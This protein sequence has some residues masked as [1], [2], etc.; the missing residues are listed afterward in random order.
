MGGKNKQRTKGNVRPSSS[1]RAAEL[2]AREN[3]VVPGFVGFGISTSKEPGYVPAVHGAE[4]IDNLVDADFRLVLRKLSKRDT[5]TKLKAVQEF[6]AMC[7]ERDSDTVAGVLPYWPRIYCKISVDHDRRLREATQQ[8]FEQLILKVKRNLAPYLKGI[9]GHWLIAQCDTYS[10]AASAAN[11][12]FQAAFPL[13]KQPEALSFCKD[14][15]LTVLQDNLL[16]ET[17]DTLSD[18]QSVPEEERQA[19]YVR[20][21]TSSLLALKKLL[22]SLSES[23]REALSQQLAH[24]I[25]QGKFWKY[26][27]HNTPQ[28]RGAFFKAVA[29]LCELV[30]QLV[31]NEAARACSTVLLSIDDSDPVVLPPL[32]EAV[33]HVISSIQDC[34]SHVNARKGVLPKLWTLL[35]EGGRGLA[36]SLHPNML[37]LISKLPAEV[38]EPKLD[39]CSTFLS[40]VTQGKTKRSKI[41]KKTKWWKL[42]KEECCEEFRQRLRQALGGQVVLPDDWETT[43]EV[44]RETGRKV[45]GV[46]SG[47]RKED[48]ETWW[49]NEEVQDSIQRKRLAKK[50]WDMDRTEENRQEYEESQCRVKREVSKAKQKAY[51]ELYTRLD[52]REGEKDLYRLA[53]QRD[54]DGKDVQQV[55]VIK[56]RDGRVLTNLEKAYD[57]VPREELR[58]CMR[59][60]GVAEKYVRVVQDMYE[61]SRTVVRCAV[62][63]TEELGLHQVRQSGVMDQLSEEVRQESPLTMMFADDIVICSESR[64]QVEENL[65]RWRFALERRGMKVSRTRIKGKVYRTV[66][67]PAMLYGLET[68]SL[69]KRQE[70]ELEVAELKMLSLSSERALVSPSESAAIV[71]AT[72][73]CLR[74]LLLQNAGEDPEQRAMQNMLIVDQLLPLIDKALGSQ[75][76]QSGPLFPQIT[77]M[78]VSW[79]KRAVG[80]EATTF[81]RL[82]ADFWEGLGRICVSYV[83]HEEQQVK[84]V[85]LQGIASLLQIMQ[86][87]D[88]YCTK[89]GKRKKAVK[90]K[91]QQNSPLRS[92]HLLELVC[93]LAELNM[94]YVSERDSERHLRFLALLL[95]AFPKAEVFQ[96]LLKPDDGKTEAELGNELSENPAIRFLHQRVMVWLKQDDRKDTDFIV[97]MVFSSLQCCGSNAEQTLVLNHITV[98]LKWGVILQIIEK[99]CADAGHLEVCAGWLR[100]SVLGER[101]VRLAVELC[102]VGLKGSPSAS[103]ALDRDDHSWRLISLALSQ[104][105]DDEYL[106]GKVYVEQIIE[107]LRATLS[108]AKGMSDAGN[109]EPLVS[110]ISDVAFNFFSSLKGCLL[111]AAAVEL[112]LTIFQLCAQDQMLTHLSDT[113]REKLKHAYTAGVHSLVTHLGASVTKG[114]ILHSAAVWVKNQ[115]LTSCLNVKSLQVL[116]QAVQSLTDTLATAQ[117]SGCLL[118]QFIC[119]L[120][121]TSEEWAKLREALPPQWVKRP[122]LYGRF[123]TICASP[124]MEVWKVRSLNTLPSHLCAS[125]LL[126]KIIFSAVTAH[127]QQEETDS[128][129]LS[130]PG[131]GATEILYALQWCE[132]MEHCP[133]LVAEYHK[134]LQDWD[135][136]QKVH[137]NSSAVLETLFTRSRKEGALWSLTLASYIQKSKPVASHI[138]GLYDDVESFYPLSEQNVSTIQVLC[139]YMTTAEKEALIAL[140]IAEL[141][142]WQ[143]KEQD[144]AQSVWACL[145]V[146]DCCL[147]TATPVEDEILLAVMATMLEWRNSKEEWFL[148]N[149]DLGKVTAAQLALP[150]E[151]MRFLSWLVNHSPTVLGSTHWDFLLCSMLAWLETASESSRAFWSPCVQQFVQ[152]NCELIV[153]LNEFF[154]APPAGVME[155]LPPDLSS[156]W[157]EFFMEGIHNLLL[158]LLIK[159]P[160]EF[161]DPDEARFPVVVVEAVGEA[162]RRIPVQLLLHNTLPA[163]FVVDQKSNL[164]DALQTL[165]NTLTP[166]LLFKSRP[167]QLAVYHM[168]HKI[169]PSL[170]ESDNENASTKSEDEDEEEPSLPPPAAIMT[171]LAAT[172]ELVENVLGSVQVGEFA[173]VHPLSMEHCCIL[174]YLLAWK[175]LLVFF[176]AAPSQLRVQY[177]LHIKKTRSLHKLLLH[178]FRLMPENPALPGQLTETASREPK[179]FFTESLSLSLHQKDSLQS[180]VP[181]LACS[182]YY[183]ALK[184]LPAM[185]RLWWNSQ[186]KRVVSIVDKFTS[187]YVSSVLSAQEI[188]SVQSSTQTF[189]SMTVKARSATREV[190]ATYSVDDIFIEL[191]IQLPQ[192]YPLGS[193]I[194]ES[195]RRVGVAVQQWRNWMLQLSTYLTHQN[196]S[197]MEGLALWKNNVDK[198]FEGV[199][200]CM[201][202]FSVI[203]GSNYS[204][205]KKACRTCKKKFHSACLYKWFTSS[206]KSTCPLCRETFF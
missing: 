78:L 49:W 2:L 163:R 168:L 81:L 131:H 171:I 201:I 26:S 83:D 190:I 127:E 99:A 1:G 153:T 182:V 91:G 66:V 40:S 137:S 27:K 188:A 41:E 162:L 197:I 206:N 18:P 10:P 148:F 7:Q 20:V 155:Q 119:C 149:S 24:I 96:G 79:E 56:D 122:L 84:Q 140:S 176:N 15:V 43:A 106:I 191:V 114:T 128:F 74:F 125:A 193:I 25:S 130:D 88:S 82:L 38:T 126:G 63:Q 34:W 31:Q 11:V 30:P 147:Q 157:Q 14:E 150:V 95:Q 194:V 62:G 47:R 160:V 3:G 89:Q 70:S 165:L 16:K 97:D 35:R 135:I 146:L 111:L 145:A 39:F 108:E 92:S 136:V 184:D 142:N 167:L 139:L 64:E 169:M 161:S 60:S 180:E 110:F 6:G 195:G 138:M 151:M 170:L 199:E 112:L 123:K 185:V 134:M 44:I 67:R 100:G 52:T 183:S 54:R 68:V 72:M 5:V 21:L 129:E 107:Q 101:V 166:L 103:S 28:V 76:L 94:V 50:K 29:A 45:L 132:E 8:A 33:L 93:Q 202:C 98:D 159:I 204:L 158:P 115:L 23:D 48:K 36:T 75:A 121:P 13:N 46:S 198:R 192:N 154:A 73:E 178:L 203:H 58:Y 174:G 4:E 90:A 57:R 65:E 86:N 186:E 9:M 116:V 189:D 124:G 109:M 143:E 156:E 113:L 51:D 71:F 172:E 80:N 187:K 77:E 133:P 37:P 105:H 19:K 196:G 175:L 32:W 53:R 181:H 141:L 59:K 200:D 120:T 17:A 12:A 22:K 87:P 104:Q 85:V 177:C 205:P 118:S 173:V 55:R 117:T 179:S 61:R 164:P 69:R 42:K 152:A 102:A 144:C